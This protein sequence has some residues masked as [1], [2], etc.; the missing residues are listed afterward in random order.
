MYHRHYGVSVKLAGIT[1]CGDR[2]PRSDR[3]PSIATDHPTLN[4]R[5]LASQRQEMLWCSYDH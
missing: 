4:S 5:L 1:E 2:L 3:V